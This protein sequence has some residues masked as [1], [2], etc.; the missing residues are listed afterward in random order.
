MH[1]IRCRAGSGSQSP[2]DS[3]Q[4]RSPRWAARQELCLGEPRAGRPRVSRGILAI[5]HSQDVSDVRKLILIL[6][7][8]ALL[9][10]APAAAQSC[11]SGSA[12]YLPEIVA[13]LSRVGWNCRSNGY[14]GYRCKNG[15]SIQPDGYGGYRL[16][17]GSKIRPDSNGG[18]RNE[19]GLSSRRDGEGKWLHSDGSYSRPD[20]CGGWI[21]SDGSSTRADGVGGWRTR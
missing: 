20:G 1:R 5:S 6:L 13:V 17:N 14:G 18:W 9:S 3:G 4:A 16:S 19:R 15:V 2:K 7:L 11:E 10:P 21:H 12:S 8:P